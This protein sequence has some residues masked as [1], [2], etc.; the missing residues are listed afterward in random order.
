M[1]PVLHAI[2]TLSAFP[3][4]NPALLHEQQAAPQPGLVQAPQPGLVQALTGAT[5]RFCPEEL[6][7]LGQLPLALDAIPRGDMLA[8]SHPFR[9]TDVHAWINMVCFAPG[10][11]PREA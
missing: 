6:E 3:H 4:D 11:A 1:V 9:G 8:T 2:L 5:R 10:F 7:N